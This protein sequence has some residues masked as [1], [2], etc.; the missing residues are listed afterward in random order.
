MKHYDH[1]V[2]N[3]PAQAKSREKRLQNKKQE[4]MRR[5]QEKPPGALLKSPKT[6][7]LGM[8]NFT[9]NGK[10]VARS[11]CIKKGPHK[12]ERAIVRARIVI[13]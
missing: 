9:A 12:D 11:V 3:Y 10:R 7:H 1:T 13:N 2:A 6:R 5:S 4:A 8:I